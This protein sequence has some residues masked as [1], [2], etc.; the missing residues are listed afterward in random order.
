MG[1]GRKIG[2]SCD[3]HE[4]MSLRGEPF[5]P[6][7]SRKASLPGPGHYEPHDENLMAFSSK[8]KVSSIIRRNKNRSSLAGLRDLEIKDMGG[9]IVP[10]LLT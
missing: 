1:K 5:D 10:N 6:S 8:D 4:I 7:L 3:L 2:N 9:D